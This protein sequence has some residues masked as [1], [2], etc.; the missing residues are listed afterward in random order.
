MIRLLGPPPSEAA[1]A[2][3]SHCVTWGS[4]SLA[5]ASATDC[6]QLTAAVTASARASNPTSR[7]LQTREPF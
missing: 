4:S 3:M 5:R 2:A 6:P 7:R 1:H